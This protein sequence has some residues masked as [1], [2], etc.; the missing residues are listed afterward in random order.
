M[1]RRSGPSK[2]GDLLPQ[3]LQDVGVAEQIKR[4]SVVEDWVERVGEGIA[5]VARPRIVS[6]SV[7]VV[8]VRSSAW[9]HELSMMKNEILRR[10]NEDR[11]E[12]RIEGLHFTLAQG[13][14]WPGHHARPSE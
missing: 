11:S 13:P 3:V 12:G 9:L 4:A 6:G 10:L 1:S 8:E 5:R 7:L 14:E 2:V